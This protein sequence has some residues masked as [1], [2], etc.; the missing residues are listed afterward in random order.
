[1]EVVVL[2]KTSRPKKLVSIDQISV[3]VVIFIHLSK[4]HQA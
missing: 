4:P 3:T 2:A 1:M